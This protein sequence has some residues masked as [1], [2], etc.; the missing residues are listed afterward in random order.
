MRAQLKM[1]ESIMVL[2]IFIFLVAFGLIVYF[3]FAR[4]GL[5]EQADKQADLDA[6][7]IA[8]KIQHLPEIQA[9]EYNV[10]GVYTVD[11]TKLDAIASVG[12]RSYRKMFPKTVLSV[13]EFYPSFSTKHVYGDSPLTWKSQRFF[14]LP[15][16]IFDPRTDKYS[17]GYL[18]VTVYR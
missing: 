15:V 3:M 1:A 10:E 17:M 4:S 16:A 13:T 18:N 14:P 6:L 12:G 5:K 2:V 7:K 9:T 11:V 8:M